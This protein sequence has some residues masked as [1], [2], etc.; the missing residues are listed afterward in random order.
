M[1]PLP[2]RDGSAR[3]VSLPLKHRLL[4]VGFFGLRVVADGAAPCSAGADVGSDVGKVRG[5]GP[6]PREV[7]FSSR[8]ADLGLGPVSC[9]AGVARA[10]GSVLPTAGAQRQWSSIC[11]PSRSPCPRVANGPLAPARTSPLPGTCMPHHGVRSTRRRARRG[12][13]RPDADP[14]RI[15]DSD[16]RAQ[17]E[18]GAASP[19]LCTPMPRRIVGGDRRHHVTGRAQ[20]AHHV[21][22]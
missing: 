11:A 3:V 15:S 4:R 5:L 7:F 9:G 12:V 20:A 17:R 2:D 22:R 8:I 21:G 6:S 13:S 19:R 1:Y 18:I 16:P 10:D 14:R